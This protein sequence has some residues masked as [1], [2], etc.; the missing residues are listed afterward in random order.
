MGMTDLQ[1][2]FMQI[3]GHNSV[4]VYRIP[5]KVGTEILLMSPLRVPN[6]SPI[7]ARIHVLWQILRSVQK[8]AEEKNE[9]KK[10]PNWLL[11]SRK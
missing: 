8:E 5:T 9:K 1:P 10:K 3:I 6:F 4:N 2:Y 11:V 7:G